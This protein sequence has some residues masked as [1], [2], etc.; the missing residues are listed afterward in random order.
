MASYDPQV[1]AKAVAELQ[2]LTAELE[3]ATA[4]FQANKS[5]VEQYDAALRKLQPQLDAQRQLLAEQEKAAQAAARAGTVAERA[6]QVQ[7]RAAESAATIQKRAAEDAAAI[8]AK[9][10]EQAAR[11]Q[12]KAAEKAAEI[13]QRAATQAADHQ[14]KEAQRAAAIQA[15]DAQKAADIQAAASQRAADIQANAAQIAADHQAKEAQRAAEIQAKQAQVAEG[16]QAR[17]ATK[18]AAVQVDAAQRA[19]AIQEAEATRAAA[20]QAREATRAATVQ[21]AQSEAAAAKVI[22]A[23]KQKTAAVEAGAAATKT[24]AASNSL[25]LFQVGQIIE[26]IQYG[27]HSVINNIAFIGMMRG[28][29]GGLILGITVL[30]V[31]VSQLAK[32]WDDLTKGF[33]TG[34][35]VDALKGTAGQIEAILDDAKKRMD[36]LGKKKFLDPKDA[37][38]YADARKDALIAEQQITKENEKQARLKALE[39]M[40]TP[41]ER[42]RAKAFDEVVGERGGVSFEE[43]KRLVIAQNDADKAGFFKKNTDEIA[44]LEKAL[45]SG[46]LTKHLPMQ[47]VPAVVEATQLKIKKLRQEREAARQASIADAENLVANASQGK[48][49]SLRELEKRFAAER[50]P[51]TGG[52]MTATPQQRAGALLADVRNVEAM[53][54]TQKQIE[55]EG[56]ANSAA[57]RKREREKER[58]KKEEHQ[59]AIEA[60]LLDEMELQREQA[61]DRAQRALNMGQRPDPAD[62][63]AVRRP[64]VELGRHRREAEWDRMEAEGEAARRQDQEAAQRRRAGP[65]PRQGP[66][67]PGPGMN[68]NE[69]MIAMAGMNPIDHLRPQFQ[70]GQQELLQQYEQAMQRMAAAQAMGSLQMVRQMAA[71]AQMTARQFHQNNAQMGF[72]MQQWNQAQFRHFAARPTAF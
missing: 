56:E 59:K 57:W 23:E 70:A 39:N 28:W 47:A 60:D 12:A 25:V 69:Q 61:R 3:A 41:E 2:R 26:D 44:R 32:R 37:V 9:A 72:L 64:W 22:A 16:I 13:Q 68:P 38:A 63:N 40:Q 51:N 4:A 7:A 50:D 36:E 29:S 52:F 42:Q 6:A 43:M 66:I 18:A 34:I 49:R 19:A 24:S 5:S 21:A 58:Q 45:E 10:A 48:E 71:I 54:K 27:I 35:P 53:G 30:G 62:E 46:E 11:L 8:Q 31:A 67:L 20:A 65:L 15:T 17:A 55:A 33:R 1:E 14:A